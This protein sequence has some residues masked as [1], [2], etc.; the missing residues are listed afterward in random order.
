MSLPTKIPRFQLVP[1]A[2]VAAAF[3]LTYT[4]KKRILSPSWA[5][6]VAGYQ[7]QLFFLF[8]FFSLGSWM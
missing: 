7:R 4:H 8:I 3:N 1:A 6:R 2:P 5:R